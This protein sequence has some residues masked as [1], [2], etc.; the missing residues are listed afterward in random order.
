MKPILCLLSSAAL[1]AGC[2]IMP[3]GVQRAVRYQPKAPAIETA[4]AA[5]APAAAPAVTAPVADLPPATPAYP[6]RAVERAPVVTPAALVVPAAEPM[7]A[8]IVPAVAVP[9]QPVLT[10]AVLPQVAVA[11]PPAPQ[12]PPPRAARAPSNVDEQRQQQLYLDVIGGLQQRGLH[13][14][15]LAHLDDYEKQNGRS[16]RTALMR[17]DALAAIG[18]YDSAEPLYNQLVRTPLAGY[19][20]AGVGYIEGARDRWPLALAAFRRSVRAEPTNPR[21]LNNLGYAELRNGDVRGAQGTLLRAEELDPANP[22]IRN[23]VILA[24]WLSGER[25][26]ARARIA[27]IDLPAE[28]QAIET[29]IAA[30]TPETTTAT[31]G[32][33][34]EGVAR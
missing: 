24:L 33:P 9:A 15:A 17:A 11:V 7:P 22:G 8:A 23:N 32:T 29:V 10:Q 21:F 27:R 28:R 3:E 26:T 25:D 1:L 18:D 4:E 19:G 30:N 20:H 13:R 16:P 34:A 14:A 31:A 12:E 2:A 5:P 6:S